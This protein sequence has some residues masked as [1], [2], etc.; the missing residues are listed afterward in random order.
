MCPCDVQLDR[1]MRISRRA[2][3]PVSRDLAFVSL[4]PATFF[5]PTPRVLQMTA[6]TAQ[7][8]GDLVDERR[9]EYGTRKRQRL[10][11]GQGVIG[12]LLSAG[13][14]SCRS[15]S[16]TA[17]SSRPF[18]SGWRTPAL[19]RLS[20]VDAEA[21]CLGHHASHPTRPLTGP[22]SASWIGWATPPAPRL[23]RRSMINETDRWPVSGN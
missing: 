2:Y 9:A 8:F 19:P 7:D 10:Y 6:M 22:R 18:S 12:E 13:K 4:Y 14:I 21:I 1:L 5:V 20:P 16:M 17:S 23:T 3:C 11:R 15:A